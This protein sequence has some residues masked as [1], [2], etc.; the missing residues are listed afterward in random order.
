MC[1]GEFTRRADPGF[2][3]QMSVDV[4]AVS[5]IRWQGIRFFEP[6]S[7]PG[8]A[9]VWGSVTVDRGATAGISV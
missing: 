5:L 1:C 2:N 8:Q 7:V 9:A 4:C 6:G 3:L